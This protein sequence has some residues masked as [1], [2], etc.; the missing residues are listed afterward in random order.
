MIH[1]AYMYMKYSQTISCINHT[2]SGK[3]ITYLYIIMYMYTY[4]CTVYTY[5]HKITVSKC[6]FIPGEFCC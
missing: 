2:V 5:T 3:S 6:C 4:N 1:V